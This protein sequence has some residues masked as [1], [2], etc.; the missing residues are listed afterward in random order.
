MP[1]DLAEIGRRAVLAIYVVIQSAAN[2]RVEII[3]REAG[4][5]INHAE[6]ARTE[7]ELEIEK[8]EQEATTLSEERDA[9]A[10]SAQQAAMRTERAEGQRE[11]IT[12]DADRLRAELD[13]QRREAQRVR[14]DG[15]EERGQ[16]SAKLER[17]REE[18]ARLP[19][20]IGAL[21]QW[22]KTPA[23]ASAR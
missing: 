8:L 17:A 18:S 16:L 14:D 1:A 13:E 19:T 2:A 21:Q 9:A 15:A 4:Q 5:R 20:Q 12:G 11:A 7:A 23:G 10:A 3:E 6:R 22:Q